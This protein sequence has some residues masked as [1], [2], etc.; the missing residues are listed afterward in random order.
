METKSKKVSKKER[1]R[2]LK[3]LLSKK[4]KFIECPEEGNEFMPN[5]KE[6]KMDWDQYPT[7]RVVFHR[8]GR[9]SLKLKKK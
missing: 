3:I 6:P 4:P 5:K 8:D 1:E 2:V 7:Y 9:T